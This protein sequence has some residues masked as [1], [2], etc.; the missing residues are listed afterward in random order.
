MKDRAQ[1][2]RDSFDQQSHQYHNLFSATTN[3][4]AAFLFRCR[5][6]LTAEML[7][8]SRGAFL[9]CA[10]GT[11]EI[12]RAVIEKSQFELVAINDFSAQMVHYCRRTVGNLVPPDRIKW[13]VEDAFSLPNHFGV[14]RFDVVLCLGLIA[15]T[16][17]LPVLMSCIASLLQPDGIF[18]LQ[19]SL[20]DNLGV[21]IAGLIGRTP[22]RRFKYQLESFDLDKIL[23]AA[24]MAGLEMIGIRRYGVCLPFGDRLLGPLNYWLEKKWALRCRRRG[25]EA[26]MLFRKTA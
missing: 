10:S 9:D 12:T 22:L 5:L 25:G 8:N 20:S 7:G 1:I 6:D 2:V 4:G 23:V 11:G 15:H 3:T 21:R 24:E 16:G 17:R 26:L 18:L 19:S 14:G 13:C